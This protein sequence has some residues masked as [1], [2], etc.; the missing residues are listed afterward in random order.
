MHHQKKYEPAFGKL[1]QRRIAPAQESFKARLTLD[2]KPER[3]KMQRQENRKREAGEAMHEGCGPQKAR[4]MPQSDHEST[5]APT[6][7]N[8]SRSR[9]H[10]N[11]V[12]NMPEWRWFM[13]DHSTSTLCAP[14]AA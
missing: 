7:R 2:G 5:T 4:A 12:A 9:Q 1:D 8:P 14:M 6:A 3:Q 13:G 11:I 10:P